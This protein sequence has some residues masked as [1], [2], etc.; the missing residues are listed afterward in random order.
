MR[1]AAGR[2]QVG[3]GHTHR[4]GVTPGVRFWVGIGPRGGACTACTTRHAARDGWTPAAGVSLMP[5][6]KH[7]Y[8][9]N[10]AAA[11][12]AADWQ[13]GPMY[14]RMVRS[15]GKR[16]R[17]IRP[18]IRRLLIDHPVASDSRILYRWLAEDVGF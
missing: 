4:S 16:Y 10:L 18:L 11:L 6:A 14:E 2:V 12:L 8:L 5:S 1:P 9:S 7:H 15:S 13:P 17:W 3:W